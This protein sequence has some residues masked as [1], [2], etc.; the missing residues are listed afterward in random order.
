L[1]DR[2][3]AAAVKRSAGLLRFRKSTFS[4][5]R[6]SVA[7]IAALRDASDNDR[8]LLSL[9]FELQGLLP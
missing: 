6:Q 4:G 7:V 9:L 8:K 2:G 1:S 3:L 5:N